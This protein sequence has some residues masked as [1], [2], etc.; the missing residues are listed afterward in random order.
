MGTDKELEALA[1]LDYVLC[2]CPSFSLFSG[3]LRFSL[4]PF[5]LACMG[6][7]LQQSF[8]TG[9]LDAFYKIVKFEG[10]RALY[11][12]FLPNLLNVGAGQM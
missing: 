2:S 6:I 7:P 11:K 8:Y 12:G 5:L 4:P 3:I 10:V 1:D 9:T